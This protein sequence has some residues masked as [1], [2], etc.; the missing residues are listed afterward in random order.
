MSTN[1]NKYYDVCFV[2]MPYAS[3]PRPSIAL[4][5]LKSIL[6][7]ADI[8]CRIVYANLQFVTSIGMDRY[9]LCAEMLPSELYF[10]DW[11]FSKTVFPNF[12]TDEETYLEKVIAVLP[13]PILNSYFKRNK[14]EIKQYLKDIREKASEFVDNLAKNILEN[15]PKIVACTST[16]FQHLSSIALLKK[17]R[18]LDPSVITV[19]GGANCNTTMGITTHK[20]FPWIDYVFSGES[21][22]VIVD[23]YKKM[24]K[25]GR[26]IDGS[27]LPLNIAGP[28]DRTDSYNRLKNDRGYMENQEFHNLDSLPLP[29]Y[30]EFFEEIINSGLNKIISPGL[31]METSRGCWWNKC[32]FCG[33]NCATKCYRIKSPERVLNEIKE[34][35]KKYCINKIET[36]DNILY[37][38]FFNNVLK[39]LAMDKEKHYLFFESKANLKKTHLL[40]L[41]EAGVIWLQPGIESLMTNVLNIIS[42]GVS[43]WQNIQLL[44]WAR[45]AGIRLSW[46][47]LWGFPG[48]KDEWYEEMASM[49]HLLEHLQPP[50]VFLHVRIHRYSHFFDN[51]DKYN[52]KL[53]PL[54]SLSYIYDLPPEAI[55]GLSYTFI[56]EGWFNVFEH[57]L[58]D[59]Y[60]D[61]PGAYNVAKKVMEWKITFW[62][63]VSPILGVEDDGEILNFI[64]TRRCSSQYSY[65][66][67]GFERLIY[68][69]C[70]DAPKIQNVEAVLKTKYDIELDENEINDILNRLKALGV[71]L[72][73]D[74]RVLSLAV[75]GSIPR[76]PSR[77]DFPGGTIESQLE[78]YAMTNRKSLWDSM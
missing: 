20:S 40:S 48:E 38:D 41:K 8:G 56:P 26:K 7:D 11:T 65:K 42:K 25:F 54:S 36:V 52:L 71:V 44:K 21:D 46:N 63:R 69:V 50:N 32:K 33:L 39:E 78:S 43:G 67:T 55:N 3:L 66:L 23:A 34:L 76:L 18:E 19:M 28:C 62:N 12:E 70:E 68:L 24:L 35:E 1:T 9:N 60:R 15:S 47:I 5:L 22:G 73:I 58:S 45:E 53:K 29:S 2:N 64:D 37:M 10:S 17:I 59:Q 30:D 75:W 57:P 4:G 13:Y 6:E 14:D 77:K 49:L 31:L 72:S 16:F 74:G 27:E 51:A 61:R